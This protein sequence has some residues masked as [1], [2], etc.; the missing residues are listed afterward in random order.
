MIKKKIRFLMKILYILMIKF[1]NSITRYTNLRFL[2]SLSLREKYNLKFS[3]KT[4]RYI[5]R[6]NSNKFGKIV[7]DST[8]EETQLCKIGARFKTNKSSLNLDGHRSGYTAFYN[9]ILNPL[10]NKNCQIAEIGIEKN[11]STKMWRKYFSKAKIDCFEI[12]KEKI[13]FALEDKLKKVKYHYIDVEKKEIIIKQFQKVKKKYDL[14]IDDSTHLFDHQINIIFGVYK[15]LKSG[16]ILIVEDIYKFKKGYEEEKYY[17]RIKK[18]KKHFSYIAFV[19]TPH[20]NNFTAG[21][22]NEKILILIKK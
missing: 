11:A 8:L 22:K 21:W 3:R 9:L 13:N 2:P 20:A 6:K 5:L 7:I 15:F 14:I 10:I 16:G 4:R 1:L 12:D 17:E 18:I 19:E